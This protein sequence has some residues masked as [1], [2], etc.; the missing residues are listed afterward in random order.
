MS[1]E[2]VAVLRWK[3]R[4]FTHAH[5]DPRSPPYDAGRDERGYRYQWTEGNFGCDCNR[6]LFISWQLDDD[7]PLWDDDD[8]CDLRDEDGTCEWECGVRV[9]LVS[10]TVDG[11]AVALSEPEP[12]ADLWLP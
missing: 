7:D 6:K 11:H 1:S 4:Q 9:E 12:V 10:L 3:G 2:V 5:T 8:F